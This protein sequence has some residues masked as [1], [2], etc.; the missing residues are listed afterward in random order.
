MRPELAR[1]RIEHA[2]DIAFDRH[3]ALDRDR[4]AAGGLHR[5]DHAGCGLGIA[6]VVD[7][8]VVAARAGQPRGRCTDAAA[9]AGDKKDWTWH[10]E[11]PLKIVGKIEHDQ[12]GRR[13]KPAMRK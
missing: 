7:R 12:A 4:L 6:L 5:I 8:H 2:L 13:N 3:V 10:G 11:L 9:A 1:R